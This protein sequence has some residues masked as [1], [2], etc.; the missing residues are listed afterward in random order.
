MLVQPVLYHWVLVRGIVV[1]D[2]M[3]RLILGRLAVDLLEELQPLGVAVARLA[4]GND[5]AV[6]HIH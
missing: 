1:S 4:L 3:Q 2:Q 5:L 6:Q